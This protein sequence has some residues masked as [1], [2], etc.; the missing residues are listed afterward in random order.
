MEKNNLRCLSVAAA[1]GP[2]RDLRGTS[3]Q[4]QTSLQYIKDTIDFAK[5]DGG[6]F[7]IVPL[8][9]SVGRANAV[10]ASDYAIQEETVVAHLKEL[11]N[12]Q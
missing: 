7:A 3:Q 5:A 8:Y 4:Q 6:K 9:S 1:F 11:C 12:M 2:D 10:S